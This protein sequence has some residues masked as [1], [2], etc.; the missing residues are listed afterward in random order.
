[1]CR[2]NVRK[3]I[4]VNVR[5][6]AWYKCEGECPNLCQMVTCWNRCQ[7][8]RQCQ[9]ICQIEMSEYSTSQIECQ[10]ICQIECQNICQKFQRNSENAGIYICQIKRLNLCQIWYQNIGQI[11]PDRMSVKKSQYMSEWMSDRMPD[12]ICQIKCHF[13]YATECQK[14]CK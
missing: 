12:K 11:D 7:I 4:S 10:W 9:N 8:G 14:I 13:W 2:I 6:N 3:Y 1:M 5:Y